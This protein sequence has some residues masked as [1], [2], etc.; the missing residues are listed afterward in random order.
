VNLPY[1]YRGL[2][3]HYGHRVTATMD[4]SQQ[5]VLTTVDTREVVAVLFTIETFETMVD[6]GRLVA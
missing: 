6:D 2:N 5:V 4:D 3:T 1:T